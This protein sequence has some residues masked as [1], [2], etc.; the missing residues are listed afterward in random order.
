[1]TLHYY[2]DR[3]EL[4][5]E[6]PRDHSYQPY[7]GYSLTEAMKMHRDEYGI[8]GTVS[9]IDKQEEDYHLFLLAQN[10]YRQTH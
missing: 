6:S 7:Q 2:Y 3:G 9:W 4:F 1:M 8:N 10:N 5:I